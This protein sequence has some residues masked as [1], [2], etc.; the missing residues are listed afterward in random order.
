MSTLDSYVA[1]WKRAKQVRAGASSLERISQTA[2]DAFLTQGFP[3]TREEEWRFT[4]VAPIADSAFALV[5]E[6]RTAGLD[7]AHLRLPGGPA[8]ELVFVD[9]RYVAGLSQVGS[10]PHGVRAEN[11][12]SAIAT[13][14]E[15]IAAY[16][17]RVAPFDRS[18]FVALNTAFLVDGALIELAAGTVLQ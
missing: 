7:I 13:P 6:P 17:T 16:L 11:L 10:L 14:N 5:T 3:T 12:A 1:E 4:S 8:A 9:G 2:F 15:A 18:P